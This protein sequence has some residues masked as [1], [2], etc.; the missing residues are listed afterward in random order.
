MIIYVL[1]WSV[2]LFVCVCVS[3]PRIASRRDVFWVVSKT[4]WQVNFCL[5]L[6]LIIDIIFLSFLNK[7]S[8]SYQLVWIV[9]FLYFYLLANTLFQIIDK[10][11]FFRFFMIVHADKGFVARGG[12]HQV[13]NTCLFNILFIV[14]FVYLAHFVCTLH[15]VHKYWLTCSRRSD[16][17]APLEHPL[18]LV[19][20][21][22]GGSLLPNS[23]IL[24]IIFG[25]LYGSYF[26]IQATEKYS[27]ADLF[28]S[29][30][31]LY[32]SL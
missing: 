32:L 11:L 17:F 13:F 30:W 14:Y 16:Q 22:H 20:G 15:F 10:N 4:C 28:C 19:H 9:I 7:H 31:C 2:C 21:D 8:L 24:V 25:S 29:F 6:F 18:R 27:A 23:M 1:W 26:T 12:G 3:L 5:H